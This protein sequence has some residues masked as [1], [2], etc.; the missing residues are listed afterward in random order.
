MQCLWKEVEAV[1]GGGDCVSVVCGVCGCVEWKK[2]CHRS[3]AAGY[4]EDDGAASKK[5]RRVGQMG[6]GDHHTLIKSYNSFL[7]ALFVPTWSCA[8]S[9]C[10]TYMHNAWPLVSQNLPISLLAL[11]SPD[12]TS[13]MVPAESNTRSPNGSMGGK[14][15]LVLR[16][17]DIEVEGSRV[18]SP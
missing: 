13:C 5:A 18:Y 6:R 15:T 17:A 8:V 9:P 1:E 12:L 11:L 16:T 7:P 4:I 2:K 14:M 3:V 10:I